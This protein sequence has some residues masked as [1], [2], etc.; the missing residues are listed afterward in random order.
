MPS[1]YHA[2]FRYIEDELSIIKTLSDG[3][4]DTSPVD[5][6]DIRQ[7]EELSQNGD[8]S[9]SENLSRQ[10][11]KSLFAIINGDNQTLIR[12]L[13]E[14]DDHG[15]RL[16][17]IV[18][19]ESPASDL[20]FELLYHNGFLVPLRMHLTR[21]VSDWGRKRTPTSEN[22]PLKILFM[23][24]SPQDAYPVLEYEKEEEMIFEVTEDLPVE[25]HVEDTGSLEGLGERLATNEYDVVHIM[26]HA[27]IGDNNN[28]FFLMEDEEGSSVQVTPSQL[29]EQLNLNLP[30]LVFLSGCRTGETPQHT[31]AASFAQH[32]VSGH[33]S[34]VLG[35]GLP[36]SDI[37]ARFA[38]RKLYFELSRG[39]NML[40]AVFETRRELFNKH[41][42]DWSLLRL[43]SDGTP[44]AIPL[45]EKGQKRR[46]KPRE[47]QYGYLK[48]SQVKVIEK[49][50]IG[51]RRQIQQGLRCLRKDRE[52][53]GLLLYGT[54]GLGKSCLAGK[55][56]E[57]LSEHDL[58]IVH[59]KLNELTLYEALKSAFMRNDDMVGEELLTMQ[60][61]LPDKIRR[62]CSSVFQEKNYLILLDDFEQNLMVEGGKYMV[63]AEAVPIL[64]TLL[65]FLPNSAKMTQLIITSRHKFSLTIDGSDLVKKNLKFIGL[66]SFLG[67][68]KRKKVIELENIQ[69]CPDE[70]RQ[71]LIELGKGNPSLLDQLDK[72]VG[73]A[74]HLDL[75]LLLSEAKGKQEEFISKLVLRRIIESQ[76]EEFQRFLRRSAVY[77]RPVIVKGLELVC[78]DLTDWSS[79]VGRAVQLSLMEEDGT[80]ADAV[81]YWVTPLIGEDIFGELE[82]V[83]KREYH[84][85]AVVYYQEILSASHYDPLASE[86]LVEHALNAGLGD[87]AVE[88][89]GGRFLPYL[90]KSP[91]YNKALAE[92]E[93]ILSHIHELKRDDK[94]A[95]FLFELGWI[96]DD[97]GNARQAIEY[98][99][100]ALSIR[101]KIYGD[102]N[103]DVAT[104]LNNI[105]VAWISLGKHKKAMEYCEQALS[106]RKKLYD[107]R[108][109]DVAV[110]LNNIGGVQVRLGKHK[111]A[112]EY[113]EQ[114]LSINKAVYGDRHPDVATTLNNIGGALH[115]LGEYE[116]AIEYFKQALSITKEVYGNRH[117]GVATTLNNIGTVQNALGEHKRAIEYFEQSLSITKAVYG[118]RHPDVATTL[119]NIGGALHALDAY[120]KAIE[121]YEQALSISEGVYGDKHHSV[122]K[123]LN[124]IGSAWQGLG[125]YEKAI[126]CLER[127][128]SINESAYSDPHPDVA[129]TLN[130]IGGVWHDLGKHKKAIECYEQALSIYKA[131]YGDRHSVVA[132][133]LNNIGMAQNA[134]GEHKSAI[135]YFEQALSIHKGVY[136]DKHPGVVKILN[137]IGGELHALDEYEKAIECFKQALSITMGVYGDMHPE[138]AANLYNIGSAWHDLGE[139]KKAIEYYE[140]ALSIHKGVYGDKHSIVARNLNSIGM[141]QNAL[142]EHKSAIGYF[143]QALS[144]TEAMYSDPHPDVATTLNKIGLAWH[145]LGEHKKAIEYY[146]RAL[147]IYKEVC[148]DMHHEVTATLNNIGMAWYACGDRK[149]A[150]TYVRQ[151]YNILR[152]FYGDE[153]LH[154]RTVKKSLELLRG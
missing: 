152:E 111:K 105:G 141:A 153:Y 79:D 21:H 84:Q 35:W 115:A 114:A 33:V 24:C 41:S 59:G 40:D 116:K 29:W 44:L 129:T 1:T 83:E 151:A 112:M 132:T 88:E 101:K 146:E 108:H 137:N 9:Y 10:I 45:V 8:W 53:I 119:N 87:V 32:L 26:G 52:K 60:E 22:R 58:I 7:L 23:A 11:G 74:K 82:V 118:D 154:T 121:Y 81:R 43:F 71:K 95:T 127:A 80:R 67:A 102:W 149:R 93:H 4:P 103:P 20:P 91:S 39:K 16:R 17:M 148:G 3:T 57:R 135:E 90:R 130:N 150:K 145:D 125:R 68:D 139:H 106:I 12:A 104:T 15:E 140:R 25:L 27:G 126:E 31:A 13:R 78:G 136:G 47:L 131:V 36:V 123:S 42:H 19:G 133:T 51:R 107:D 48:G 109:P 63:S 70:V 99:E 75:E 18:S 34:A 122:S 97:I 96:Y 77:R 50:F 120:E 2:E 117:S 128:L 86:E 144:I 72:L 56:S 65:K 5:A 113:Y 14:A 64:E 6:E 69:K 38:A 37:G 49:G 134:L 55:F 85:A 28:P 61:E 143:E 62:M 54:G 142:G 30:G 92:G 73:D 46:P 100:Q 110:T 94:L 147:S 66:T 76:S 124:N 98:Y 138:V 89:A